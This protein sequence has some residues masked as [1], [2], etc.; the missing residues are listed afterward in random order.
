MSHES[1]IGRVLSQSARE[2]K[3]WYMLKRLKESWDA[4]SPMLDQARI[5]FEARGVAYMR[6]NES[7]D[8]ENCTE[9][10]LALKSGKE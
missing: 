1:L 9:E 7:G 3:L 4:V 8:F 2:Q 5:D 10:V 6:V